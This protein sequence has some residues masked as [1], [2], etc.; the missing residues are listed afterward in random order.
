[1]RIKIIWAFF[2]WMFMRIFGGCFNL[3]ENFRYELK[4]GAPDSIFAICGFIILW[5]IAILVTLLASAWLIEDKATVAIIGASCFWL[6]VFTF[7]YNA[8]K[9]SWECFVRERNEL[10]ETLRNS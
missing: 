7:V 5:L 9:A 1:M 2:V 10:I 4:K 6:A 8:I 3:A